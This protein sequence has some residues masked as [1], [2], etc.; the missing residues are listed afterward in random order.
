L[1]ASQPNVGSELKFHA[2]SQTGRSGGFCRHLSLPLSWP[3]PSDSRACRH[4]R[5]EPYALESAAGPRAR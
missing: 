2:R 1:V 4:P 3:K 5:A